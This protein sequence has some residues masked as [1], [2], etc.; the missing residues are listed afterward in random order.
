MN[1][2]IRKTG[3][4]DRNIKVII[5]PL[6]QTGLELQGK[7]GYE[8]M[9]EYKMSLHDLFVTIDHSSEPR[10]QHVSCSFFLSHPLSIIDRFCWL[11]FNLKLHKIIITVSI[12]RSDLHL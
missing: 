8:V 5:N 7:I 6:Q 4:I 9:E 11:T 2:Y 1:L 12:A 10:C 3:T